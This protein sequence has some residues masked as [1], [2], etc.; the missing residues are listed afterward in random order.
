MQAMKRSVIAAILATVYLLL[1]C[2][3]LQFTALRAIGIG[4]YLFSPV[5]VVALVI[6]VV[7]GDNYT[8]RELA[9]GE[10]FGY[11]DKDKSQLGMF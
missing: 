11:Q 10:E 9:E 5:V 1:Y 2:C 7:K 6:A 4:M 3:C 8:G